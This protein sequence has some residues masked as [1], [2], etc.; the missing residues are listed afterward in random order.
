MHQAK[1]DHCDAYNFRGIS[2]RCMFSDETEDDQTVGVGKISEESREYWETQKEQKNKKD[3]YSKN[4]D[5]GSCT[6]R[7]VI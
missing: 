4:A 5:M 2:R 3:E 1:D 6:H 7:A